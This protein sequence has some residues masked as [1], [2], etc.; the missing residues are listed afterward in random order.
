MSLKTVITK[1]LTINKDLNEDSSV[2]FEVRQGFTAALFK[3]SKMSQVQ[4]FQA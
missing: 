2:I 1:E 4:L 3:I